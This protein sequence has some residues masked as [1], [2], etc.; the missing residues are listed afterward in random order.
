MRPVD[1]T[2]YATKI[3]GFSSMLQ[4]VLELRV[5]EAKI[6]PQICGREHLTR[7]QVSRWVGIGALWFQGN[8][9]SRHPVRDGTDLPLCKAMGGFYHTDGYFYMPKTVFQSEYHQKWS[10][11]NADL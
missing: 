11:I 10:W 5:A 2:Y 6:P 8:I 3:A 1:L 9:Y 7:Q 4:F